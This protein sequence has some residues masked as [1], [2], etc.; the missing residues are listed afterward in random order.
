MT[1]DTLRVLWTEG[2]FLEATQLQLSDRRHEALLAGR[3][4]AI[5][6]ISWG[7]VR[8]EID[9]RQLEGGTVRLDHFVGVLPE[10]TLVAFDRDGACAPPARPVEG[11]GPERER[12]AVWLG[13]ARAREG[14]LQVGDKARYTREIRRVADVF[15]PGSEPTD[16]EL[17]RENLRL[18]FGHE[19]R[20]DFECIEVAQI[21]RAEGGQLVLDESFVPPCLQIGGADALG[22]GLERLLVRMESRRRSLLASRRERD[23]HTIEA[24]ATD[25]ARFVLL[26][27]ISQALPV[28]RQMSRARE[29]SPRA[30]HARLLDLLGALSTFAIDADLDAP[31]F[32][33]RDLRATF[34]PLFARLE[35]LL[36]ESHRESCFVADFLGRDDGLHMLELDDRLARCDRFLV[37]VRSPV[38]ARETASLVP[39]IGKVASWSH[40]QG[41]VTSALPGARLEITHRPPPEVPVRAGDVYFTIETHGQY[42]SDA[43]AHRRLAMFLPRP[44]DP[45]STRVQLIAIPARA[46]ASAAASGSP[47]TPTPAHR[48]PPPPPPRAARP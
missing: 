4:D 33:H 30:L 41:V 47:V 31:P 22:A 17:G 10:G 11:L 13:L 6:P 20:E 12:I 7:V 37:A 32:D 19:P 38:D 25:V 34:A 43:V 44:F 5:D 8:L 40:I 1:T 45:A 15:S 14:V 3:L 46:L 18:L 48:P 28:L 23:A 26:Y 21:V 16:V 9:R 35:R 2:Q 36:S 29:A 42:W 24:D 39:S 27:G